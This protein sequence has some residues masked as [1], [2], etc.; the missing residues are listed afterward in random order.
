MT[1]VTRAVFP[2][3]ALMAVLAL[4][5][6]ATT[7]PENQDNACRIFEQNRS[8][9]KATRRVEK[10]WG[11]PISLQLAFMKKESSFDRKARPPRGKF[12][13]VFPG[14][15]ASSAKGYAQALDM[16]WDTYRNDTGNRGARRSN[17]ADAADFIGWYV[18]Q[19]AKRAGIAKGDPYNQYLAY[20]EG[21]GGYTRGSYKKKPAVKRRALQVASFAQTYE[22]QLSKCEKK[23]RRGIPLVPFI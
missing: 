12:L 1:P 17:F 4:S 15:R 2:A 18:D 6:C 5:A 11:A 13:F 21:Q 16:T 10:K 19:S 9:Y 22:A 23:F 14:A 20:H 8:W 7:P 3:L